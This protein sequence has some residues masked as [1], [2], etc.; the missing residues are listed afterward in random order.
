M[1]RKARRAAQ[2]A[3]E[4]AQRAAQNAAVAAQRA[5]NDAMNAACCLR[6]WATRAE[7][8]WHHMATPPLHRI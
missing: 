6:V 8:A 7:H 1:N 5:V 4:E 2:K 3:A